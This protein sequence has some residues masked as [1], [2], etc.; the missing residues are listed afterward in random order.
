[1]QRQKQVMQ[2]ETISVTCCYTPL[3]LSLSL[4]ASSLTE[5]NK[6]SEAEATRWKRPRTVNA[7]PLSVSYI[8]YCGSEQR[9]NRRNCA[10]ENVFVSLAA[11][12]RKAA[13]EQRS[14]PAL[15]SQER[16]RYT[17]P[18]SPFPST[19]HA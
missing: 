14:S 3:L 16:H 5:V 10:Y 15:W 12:L 8:S 9:S 19:T 7:A 1:M 4:K 2:R 6:E 13:P 18:I 17:T 11:R